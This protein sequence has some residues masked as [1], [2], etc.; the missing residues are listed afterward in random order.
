MFC[1]LMEELVLH[2]LLVLIWLLSKQS[3]NYFQNGTIEQLLVKH[4]IAAISVGIMNG[5]PILDPSFLED[6]SADGDFNFVITRS[7][8]IIEV[9]GTAEKEPLASDVFYKMYDLAQQGSQDIF[10]FLEGKNFQKKKVG[11]FT[12]SERLK[13]MPL[14]EH[15]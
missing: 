13:K 12:L 4:D 6:S 8:N 3:K 7:G 9:Q 10:S 15:V 5:I 14:P 11:L 2:V 1:K